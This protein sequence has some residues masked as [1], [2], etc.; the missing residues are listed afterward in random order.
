MDELAFEEA[1]A[2]LERVV[3]ELEQGEMTLDEALAAFQEGVKL[4]RLCI[5]KLNKF[6]EQIEVLMEDYYAEAPSW[7]G[8]QDGGGRQK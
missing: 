7:L 3:A 8:G 2:R 1:L 4:L 5:T 6:E